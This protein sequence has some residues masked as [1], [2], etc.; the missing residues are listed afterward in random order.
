MIFNSVL[1]FMLWLTLALVSIYTIN[2]RNRCKKDLTSESIK[3]QAA[4]LNA[5]LGGI[6]MFSLYSLLHYFNPE[7]VSN[8]L[9]LCATLL[10]IGVSSVS[11]EFIKK[12][13][14]STLTTNAMWIPGGSLV[15]LV[16][17]FILLMKSHFKNKT[18]L[19]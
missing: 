9:V 5:V 3:Q 8:Y 18:S 2:F 1:T 4:Y 19:I 6:V 13:N 16:I 14:D 17:I 12:C 15:A 11:I 7:W 10:S